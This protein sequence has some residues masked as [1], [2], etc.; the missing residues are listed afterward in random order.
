MNALLIRFLFEDEDFK[1]LYIKYDKSNQRYRKTLRD[2]LESA[3]WRNYVIAS[4]DCGTSTTIINNKIFN[5]DDL[6]NDYKTYLND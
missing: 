6:Y 2:F 5:L 1:I 4:T 3:N